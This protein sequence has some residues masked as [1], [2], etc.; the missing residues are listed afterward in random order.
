[1]HYSQPRPRKLWSNVKALQSCWSL[2][3]HHSA[4]RPNEVWLKVSP[5]VS[6]NYA[7]TLLTEGAKKQAMAVLSLML[8]AV[9]RL[10]SG[11]QVT[12]C[13][14]GTFACFT[15][16]NNVAFQ[17][18]LTQTMLHASLTSLMLHAFPTQTIWH[19]LFAH[20]MVYPLLTPSMLHAFHMRAI[21]MLLL[22]EQ[23]C[24]LCSRVEFCWCG[25]PVYFKG[26]SDW[27]DSF[28]W[29]AVCG[30]ACLPVLPDNVHLMC[31]R[32][33][34]FNNNDNDDNYNNNVHL[35]CWRFIW[36]IFFRSLQSRICRSVG[37]SEKDISRS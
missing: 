4:R 14:Q 30:G 7:C 37:Q 21:C 16:A 11:H 34:P 35:L 19:A 27:A 33:I 20:K 12:I 25:L 32:F 17:T 9:D 13:A 36:Y 2:L 28:G 31:W 1:M 23:Y 29:F 24:I 18:I 5:P 26:I 8:C 10:V 15:E 22:R 3:V 6:L